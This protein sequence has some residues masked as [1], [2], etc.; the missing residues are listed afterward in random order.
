MHG[1][2]LCGSDG[3]RVVVLNIAKH[4]AWNVFDSEKICPI[5]GLDRNHII[6]VDAV[7]RHCRLCF[8]CW[9]QCAPYTHK[10]VCDAEEN[11][12]QAFRAQV[13]AANPPR[14]AGA[15]PLSLPSGPPGLDQAGLDQARPPH[16]SRPENHGIGSVHPFEGESKAAAELA[17]HIAHESGDRI[18]NFLD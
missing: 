7:E 16:R 3:C 8:Y 9:L 17:K 15:S 12:L 6:I 5:I 10:Q 4:Q 1:T 2:V 14:T 18:L 13:C 11:G